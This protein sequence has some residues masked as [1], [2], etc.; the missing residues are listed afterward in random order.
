M[1]E[2]IYKTL[3]SKKF[4]KFSIPKENQKHIKAEILERV[5][6]NEAISINYPF[7]GY[8]LWRFEEAP[9]PDWAELFAVMYVIR[10]LRPIL[11][12]YPPGVHFAWRFD[13]VVVEKLNN[14][15]ISDTETYRRG[16]E[17]ILEFLKPFTPN[18]LEFEIFLERSRYK[19]YE[20]FEKELSVE[21][22]ALRTKREK[23]GHK[24]SDEEI[25][26]IDLNVKLKPGQEDEPNW[27]EENDLVHM[28]YY[29]LQGNK[30]HSRSH[31]EVEGIVAFPFYFDT[32]N[33][34]PIGSTKA[35]VVKFWVGV[36][37][38]KKRGAKHIETILSLKQ[39]ETT[40]EEKVPLNIEGLEGKNFQTIRIID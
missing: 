35:S 19:D 25:A 23:N 24:L 1:A 14:I 33:L 12:A 7:G 38:L 36:G 30:K 18:N 11:G 16:F 13:E 22:K 29:N 8:K 20:E 3:M 37:A 32:P 2:F 34:I 15:P 39:A 40:K 31:Y 21:V 10:W 6:N 28:A 17:N 5:K 27:R 4:R 9:E 26:M